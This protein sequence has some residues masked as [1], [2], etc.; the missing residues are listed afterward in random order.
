MDDSIDFISSIDLA[1]DIKS[2]LANNDDVVCDPIDLKDKIKNFD[3]DD[4]LLI[5]KRISSAITIFSVDLVDDDFVKD[6][7]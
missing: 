2:L 3:N 7:I 1:S 6:I 5:K 4:L